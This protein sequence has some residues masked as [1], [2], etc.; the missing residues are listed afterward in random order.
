MRPHE[1]RVQAEEDRRIRSTFSLLVGFITRQS[2]LNH[3]SGY[4]CIVCRLDTRYIHNSFAGLIRLWVYRV[5][6]S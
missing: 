3:V 2:L 4:G 6:N 1:E 5:P